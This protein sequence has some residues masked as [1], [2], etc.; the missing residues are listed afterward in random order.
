MTLAASGASVTFS[1]LVRVELLQALVAT[2]NDPGRLQ[3]SVRRRYRLQHWGRL[4][5]VRR[6]WLQDGVAL[7]A[8]FVA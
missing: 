3:S 2:A 5:S 8:D 7:F 1:E 4:D 6:A